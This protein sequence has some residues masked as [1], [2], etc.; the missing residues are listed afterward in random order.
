M[1]EQ[2]ER[3]TLTEQ[4]LFT[5]LAELEGQKLTLSADIAQLKKDAAWHKDKNP[6]GI[7]KVEVK[8]IAK[9]AKIEAKRD[10]EETQEETNAVFAKYVELTGYDA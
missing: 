1:T 2:A 7:D 4:Q 5:R 9:A 6:G 10:F 8:R 3:V